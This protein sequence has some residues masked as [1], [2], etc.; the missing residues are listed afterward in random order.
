MAFVEVDKSCL[1]KYIVDGQWEVDKTQT[2]VCESGVDNNLLEEEDEEWIDV[3][4]PAHSGNWWG[5][6]NVLWTSK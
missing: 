4:Q 5:F 1:Y 6:I 3:K 2:V